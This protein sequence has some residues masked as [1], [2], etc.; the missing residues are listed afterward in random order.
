MPVAGLG[1]RWGRSPAWLSAWPQAVLLRGLDRWVDGHGGGRR[2]QWPPSQTQRCVAL[3]DAGPRLVGGETACG[4][5][6]LSRVLLGREGGVRDNRPDGWT[7]LPTLGGRA[8]RPALCR[9]I[10][11]PRVGRAASCWRRQ[12]AVRSGA[13]CVT[14]GRAEANRPRSNPV[15]SGKAPRCWRRVTLA[16]GAC[17]PRVLR[18]A[19]PRTVPKRSCPCAWPEHAAPVSQ[20]CWS[21]VAH[22]PGDSGI[23]DGPPRAAPRGSVALVCAG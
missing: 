10:S 15:A 11:T 13:R 8:P 12:P 1:E 6:V 19:S 14:S 22:E 9:R 17:G 7:L 3:L 18:A 23:V 16:P 2:P 5:A 4:P 20:A 21:T